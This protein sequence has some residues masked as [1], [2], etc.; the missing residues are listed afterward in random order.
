[1]AISLTKLAKILLAIVLAVML[2]VQGLL[3]YS[4]YIY[5]KGINYTL[6][7]AWDQALASFDKSEN[8]IPDVL[9][10][11]YAAWDLYRINLAAGRTLNQIGQ[12]YLTANVPKPRKSFA[13]YLSART[14]LRRAES[15][16][17]ATYQVAYC[18]ART[19]TALEVIYTDLYPKKRNPYDPG[20]LYQKAI[21]LRPHGIIIQYAYARHLAYK[22][23]DEK[24]GS[25]VRRMIEILP[26][27]YGKIKREDFWNETLTSQAET[28]LNSALEKDIS[29]REAHQALAD[30]Y[31]ENGAY[32]QA[33]SEYQE[34][35]DIRSFTNT[36]RNYIHM[37]K[38]QFLAGNSNE[39]DT[40]L[41]RGLQTT[42]HFQS[43]L[44]SIYYFFRHEEQLPEFIRFA[45]ST[46]QKL[47]NPPEIDV[48]I[49]QAWMDQKNYPLAKARLLRFTSKNQN[50]KAYY[51]LAK[52]AQLEQDW[53]Q[54]ELMAQK[55]TV[56]NKDNS[57]YFSLFSNALQ[58][59]KQYPQAEEAVT[60]A[61]EKSKKANPWLF[62][63]RAWTR[64]AQQKYEAAA[65]D[66]KRAF[67]LKP[68]HPDFLFR[69]AQCYER[70]ARFEEAQTYVTKAL[71]LSPDN[72]SYQKLRKR[73]K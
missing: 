65:L 66:W 49:A 62:N 17:P 60:K 10:Q 53:D 48:A 12:A 67:G 14:R 59:Q 68:D 52:I 6:D 47:L 45:A 16:D 9:G 22:G 33:V 50:A 31:S 71:D 37:G 42:T 1:M 39:S 19:E 44:N 5:Q 54:M 70:V 3:L 23:N 35:L 7:K 11:Y 24:L 29:P 20:T 72:A 4:R 55:A 32:D 8:I 18:L 46:E 73:L 41:L 2:T 56:L 28:G 43:A 36:W 38:L 69:I 27:I 26:S 40:W 30:I 64:W 51:L 63:N 21:Q 34:S 57:S 25:L 58:R 61:L 15:I 13:T